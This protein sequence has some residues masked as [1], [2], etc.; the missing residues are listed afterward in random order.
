MKFQAAVIFDFK[1]DSI[2]HAA[3]KLDDVLKHAEQ[4]HQM[5]HGHVELRTPPFDPHG[6]PTV[7]LPQPGRGTAQPGPQAETHTAVR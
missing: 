1:A 6:P 4:R 7:I 5:E 3:G 2:A